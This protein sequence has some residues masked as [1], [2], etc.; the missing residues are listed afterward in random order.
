[1]CSTSV[2][3]CAFWKCRVTCLS[4]FFLVNVKLNV[5][6]FL[7]YLSQIFVALQWVCICIYFFI[8][9]W[10][11]KWLLG[12]SECILVSFRP[13]SHCFFVLPLAMPAFCYRNFC[14]R[15]V[16]SISKPVQF[17]AIKNPSLRHSST[18][19]QMFLLSQWPFAGHILLNSALLLLLTFSLHSAAHVYVG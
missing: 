8:S 12:S 15:D 19:T 7:C 6:I 3:L 18:I 17:N 13:L 9:S 11:D 14:T 1:M 2:I 16:V 10:H 5:S 4:L